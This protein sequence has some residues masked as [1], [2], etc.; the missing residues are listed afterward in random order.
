MFLYLETAIE[1]LPIK[2]DI[3]IGLFKFFSSILLDKKPI[4]IKTEGMT[5][6]FKTAKFSNKNQDFLKILIFY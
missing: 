1:I 5:G 2:F 6:D 4:S 3:K